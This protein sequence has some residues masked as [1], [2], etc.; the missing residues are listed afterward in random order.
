MWEDV[1]EI[2]AELKEKTRIGE[3]PERNFMEIVGRSF[4]QYI[5]LNWEESQEIKDK[6]HLSSCRVLMVMSLGDQEMRSELKEFINEIGWESEWV[7]R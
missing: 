6:C 1:T 2:S 5:T 4:K 7:R 3:D